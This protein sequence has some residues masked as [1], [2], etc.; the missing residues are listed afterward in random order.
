MNTLPARQFASPVCDLKAG[1]YGAHD[2]QHTVQGFSATQTPFADAG[3]KVPPEC[4]LVADHAPSVIGGRS[5]VIAS[6]GPQHSCEIGALFGD[7]ELRSIRDCSPRLGRAV[8]IRV[9]QLKHHVLANG[10]I[11]RLEKGKHST[12]YICLP[13]AEDFALSIDGVEVSLD[14]ASKAQFLNRN[15]ISADRHATGHS[16]SRAIFNEAGDRASAERE[17]TSRT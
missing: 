3:S 10:T 9:F 16:M 6:G 12:E 1:G 5:R 13:R 4:R 17:G 11:V 8:A 15:R 14:A 7:R 2:L